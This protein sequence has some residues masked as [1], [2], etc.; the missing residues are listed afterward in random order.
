MPTAKSTA[1]RISDR[2]ARHLVGHIRKHR[3]QPGAKLPSELQI[4]AELG[5]SR[6]IIREAYRSLSMAG[7]L[8]TAN[9]RAPRVGSL[10]HRAFTR[11]FEHALATEQVSPVEILEIRAPIEVR[12]AELAAVKRTERDAQALRLNAAEMREPRVTLER[13]I[14]ADIRFH[15]IIGRA[16]GNLLFGLVGGA[17][18]E[19]LVVSVRAG[20]QH[21]SRGELGRVAEIHTAIADAIANGDAAGARRHMTRHFEDAQVSLR[22]IARREPRRSKARL[23]GDAPADAD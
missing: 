10:G 21:R 11:I 19:S 6:G 20:L 17:L 1:L 7:I 12:A 18:R 14:R 23:A 22:E 5:V 4:S 13:L 9:G 8:E 16:T 2:V 3:L 15:E